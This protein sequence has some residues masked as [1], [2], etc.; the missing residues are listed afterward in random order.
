MKTATACACA[1]ARRVARV[2]T[3]FYDSKL[4]SAGLEAPQYTL[5]MTVEQM[6]SCSPVDLGRYHSLDKT[7]VSRNLK[8]LERN[9]WIES[10]IAK[11]RRKY[12]L[13]LTP[14]GY[15]RLTD[16]KLEWAKAQEQ[17][18]AKMTAAEWAAMFRAFA[19]VTHAVQAAR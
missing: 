9:G 14:A 17:L 19:T 10:S 2:I 11:D 8:V 12:L 13:R 6:G 3:Q 5:L 16:A 18:R 4:R 15:K 7:T 1:E